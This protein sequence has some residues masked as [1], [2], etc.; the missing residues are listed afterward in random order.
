MQIVESFRDPAKGNAPREEQI[1]NLLGLYD[2]TL[3]GGKIEVSRDRA[4]LLWEGKI[5]G[6]LMVG[7]TDTTLTPEE[8]IDRY[9]ELAGIERGLRSQK[10]TLSLRPVFHWTEQRIRA[11]IFVCVLALQVERWMRQKLKTV[12]VPRAVESLRQIKV[13]EIEI[14]GKKTRAVCRPTKEQKA[15]LA[16]LGVPPVTA[17]P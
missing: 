10:S 11:H 4:A 16:A 3:S 9:K 14:G 12:P 13:G 1:R 8:V 17:M 7:T 2:V 6:M 15:M 5:D